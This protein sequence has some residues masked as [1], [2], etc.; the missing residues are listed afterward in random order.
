MKSP[1]AWRAASQAKSAVRT[2]PKCRAPV[3]DGAKRVRTRASGTRPSSARGEENEGQDRPC[4]QPE[5]EHRRVKVGDDDRHHPW[6]STPTGRG[7][8]ITNPDNA[9]WLADV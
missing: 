5:D 1:P 7:G 3:G 9:G 4:Q 2:E 8:C 6:R